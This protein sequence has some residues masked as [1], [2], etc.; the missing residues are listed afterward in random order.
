MIN[1]LDDKDLMME[2]F[3]E[4]EVQVEGLVVRK[5]AISAAYCHELAQ[6][7]RK[8]FDPSSNLNQ[9]M[10]FGNLKDYAP[11]FSIA[12]SAFPSDLRS[13]QPLFDQLIANYYQPNETLVPHIDLVDRFEDGILIANLHGHCNMEFTKNEQLKNVFLDVGDVILLYGPARWEWM[14]GIENMCCTSDDTA[15]DRISLTLRRLKECK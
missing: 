4:E 6:E 2:L 3:G 15:T 9:R 1:P 12:I 14:H 5:N 8:S 13:R 7:L 11:L 10:Q